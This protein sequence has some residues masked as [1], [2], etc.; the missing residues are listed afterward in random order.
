MGEVG[1]TSGDALCPLLK[2]EQHHTKVVPWIE[3]LQPLQANP[4]KTG[5][6]CQHPQLHELGRIVETKKIL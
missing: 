1:V 5:Q 6:S 4:F 2:Q 3:S